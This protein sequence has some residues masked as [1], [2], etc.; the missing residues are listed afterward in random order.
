MFTCDHS[1][2]AQ[3]QGVYKSM[4]WADQRGNQRGEA[5]SSGGR[6]VVGHQVFVTQLDGDAITVSQTH[7]LSQ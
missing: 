7:R 6:I 2:P 5:A 4:F 3:S 1:A